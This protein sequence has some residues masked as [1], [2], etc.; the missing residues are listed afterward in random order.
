MNDD[1]IDLVFV[2]L[3]CVGAGIIGWL[4]GHY[5]NHDKS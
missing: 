4:L 5:D 3:Q 1:W 2:L